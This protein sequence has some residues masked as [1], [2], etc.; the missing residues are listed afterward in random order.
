MDGCHRRPSVDDARMPPRSPIARFLG[1][2]V[3]ALRKLRGLTQ[4]ALGER[5]A[6]TGKFVGIIERGDGNPTVELVER[7]A[8][9][10]DVEPWELLR[11]EEAQPAG[12][13]DRA[14]RATAASER[15]SEYVEGRPA[16][17][18]ERAL[19]ILEAALGRRTR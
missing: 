6:V 11:F 15:I 4:E 18:I 8:D 2:R 16:A 7:L 9:A 19:R 13:I 17:Q 3:R 1:R 10:L 12:P 5:A 14:A